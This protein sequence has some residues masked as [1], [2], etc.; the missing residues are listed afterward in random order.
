MASKTEVILFMGDKAIKKELSQFDAFDAVVG[1]LLSVSHEELKR[2]GKRYQ[3]QRKRRN[4]AKTSPASH[5]PAA[6]S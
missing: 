2:R 1:K 4:R 5:G 6:S 3:G